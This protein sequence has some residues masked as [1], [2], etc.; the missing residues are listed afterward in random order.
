MLLLL[1]TGSV[2]C[3]IPVKSVPRNCCDGYTDRQFSRKNYNYDIPGLTALRRNCCTLNPQHLLLFDK[4][5]GGWK[6]P[7]IASDLRKSKYFV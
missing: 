7:D 6:L 1:L 2:T 5:E 3:L 4:G